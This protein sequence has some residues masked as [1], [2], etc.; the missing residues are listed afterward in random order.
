MAEEP[1]IAESE[2]LSLILAQRWAALA[3]VGNGPLGSM[4][5]Y[6]VEP[7][8]HGLLMFLSG[9]SAHTRHLLADGRASVVISV[10][11]PGHGDPQTLPRISLAGVVEVIERS[12]AEFE[13]AWVRYAARFPAAA[14]RVGLGDFQLF[15]LR[16]EQ[17]RYIGGF[18]QAHTISGDRLRAAATAGGAV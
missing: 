17:A 8:L 16:V 10:P 3:T 14:P 18:G 5:A 11:D 12:S 2:A 15:R 6:A 7:G 1:S 13:E 4:V 9:L